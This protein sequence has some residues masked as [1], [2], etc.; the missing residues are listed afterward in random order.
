MGKDRR[1]HVRCAGSGKTLSTCLVREEGD[2][3]F[4]HS[5]SST[6]GRQT[7]PGSTQASVNEELLSNGRLEDGKK[8]QP[9]FLLHCRERG[10]KGGRDSVNA[11]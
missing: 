5:F 2:F 1:G 8:V 6:Q 3:H 11:P 9:T 4:V 10:R 7:T